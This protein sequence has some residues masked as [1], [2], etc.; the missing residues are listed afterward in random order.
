MCWLPLSWPVPFRPLLGIF[1][2]GRVAEMFPVSVIHGLLAAIGVIIISKQLSVALGISSVDGNTVEVLIG[3]VKNIAETNPFVAVITISGFLLLVFHARISYKLFH[4]IPAP[5]WVLIISIPFVFW[6]DFF[7][8][9]DLNFMGR[10]YHIGPE[11]LISIPNNPLE[12]LMYPDFGMVRHLSILAYGNR[13][14]ADWF[15]GNAGKYE[16]R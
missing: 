2:L 16:S 7:Q 6:F 9:H 3:T 4:F 8:P 1:R 10:D 15:C 12:A 13:D 14:Y 11:F 5:L